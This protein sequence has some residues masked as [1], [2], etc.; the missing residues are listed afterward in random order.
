[1][2]SYFAWLVAVVVTTGGCAARTPTTPSTSQRMAAPQVAEAPE[3]VVHIVQAGQT[4]WRIARAYGID[5][6][7][8]AKA[9]GIEDPTHVNTGTPLL[10]P[11]ARATILVAP[12]PAPAPSARTGGTARTGLA[13]DFLWPVAGGA[14]LRP[15]GEPRR[16]H[17]HAGVDIRG[18]HGQS[19]LA[20]RDGVVAFCGATR[21]GYGTM[22]VLDHGGGVQTLYAHARKTL[23]QQ[24]DAVHQGQSIAEVGRT[25]NATTDHCHFE[26][27]VNNRAIDPM[28][29]IIGTTE[30][31]R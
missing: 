11:G 12:Y 25:G 15:F 1:M 14:A 21:T 30:A 6:E 19:I 18:S 28:P 23:V 5:L 2:R 26:I 8:L 20:A 17:T 10:I 4:M 27:R 13:A 22:V 3:G 7:K 29:H 9:N 16:D 31:R 24:G